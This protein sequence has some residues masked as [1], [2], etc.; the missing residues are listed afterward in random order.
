MSTIDIRHDHSLSAA[1]ARKAVEEVARKLGERVGMDWRW[2]G[3][4]LHFKRSGIDGTIA[5]A[6][7]Q[8]H[9]RAK[10]GLLLGAMKG[11]IE[12]E[13]RRVLD[14]RFS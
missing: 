12:S 8:I 13:I 9:V 6:P 5:L 4:I 1:K 10:L 3:D 11:T 7:S 2:E 14:E